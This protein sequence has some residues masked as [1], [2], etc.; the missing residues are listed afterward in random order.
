MLNPFSLKGKLLNYLIT[1]PILYRREMKELSREWEV[2]PDTATRRLREI[3]ED[4]P[5]VQL[6][7]EMKPYDGEEHIV[8]W[9][10]K[11]KIKPTTVFNF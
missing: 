2:E 9:K 10:L 7:D 3:C 6:N 5:V 4:F 8:A 1:H 11:G